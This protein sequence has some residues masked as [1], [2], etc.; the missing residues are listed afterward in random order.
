M[1]Q[2]PCSLTIAQKL[3]WYTEMA[4]EQKPHLQ[5]S[6]GYFSETQHKASQARPHMEN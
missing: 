2:V 3:R 1:D 4:L 5:C 6:V